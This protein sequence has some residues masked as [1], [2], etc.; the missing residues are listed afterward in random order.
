MAPDDGS[1]PYRSPSDPDL[2]Q[3]AP[4]ARSFQT[5]LLLLIV[6]LVGL[7]VWALYIAVL[8]FLFFRVFG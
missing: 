6:W 2:P 7:G 5:W 3:A 8:L 1:L 4:A